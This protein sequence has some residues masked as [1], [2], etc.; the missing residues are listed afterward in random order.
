MPLTR[1]NPA[2]FSSFD[3]PD[4]KLVAQAQE[5]LPYRTDAYE[6]LVKKYH[7]LIFH[8]CL[9]ILLNK[10]DAEDLTQ[11]VMLK[12]FHAI[13]R[14]EGRSTFKTWIARIATNSCLSALSKIK[15]A[16]ELKALLHDD[17]TQ[18]ESSGISTTK[19]DLDKAMLLLSPKERQILT[20]RYTAD[21][22]IEEIADACDL[23][24]SA[25]KMR[26]YRA[27]A[28]LKENMKAYQ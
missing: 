4:K 25:A 23:G 24:L 10:D 1:A 20:L 27:Q 2:T 26:L 7:A 9:K 18:V 11:E 8:I 15:R 14:F 13:T 6:A 28:T 16:K 21:L 12:I 5:E 3:D 22:S 17:P 19:R